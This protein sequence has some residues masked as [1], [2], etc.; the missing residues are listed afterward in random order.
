LALPVA[1]APL[2]TVRRFSFPP[3]GR[4]TSPVFPPKVRAA[5]SSFKGT[6][7]G[8]FG[9]LAPGVFWRFCCLAAP[10]AWWAKTRFS[11]SRAASMVEDVFARLGFSMVGTELG[12]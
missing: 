1:L 4:S 10:P 3:F 12:C 2:P 6:L 11:W 8:V 7:R 5:F 9:N